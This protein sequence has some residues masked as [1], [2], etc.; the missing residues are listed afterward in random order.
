MESAGF[1]A[2]GFDA[3]VT[4]PFFLLLGLKKRTEKRKGQ[5]ATTGELNCKLPF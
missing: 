4:V 3:L 1:R 5:K 2:L